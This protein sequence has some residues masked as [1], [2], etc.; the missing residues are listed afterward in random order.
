MMAEDVLRAQ[1]EHADADTLVEALPNGR[2]RVRVIA[3]RSDVRIARPVCETSYPLDL[4]RSVYEV[5][6]PA[7]VCDEIRRDEDPAASGFLIRKVALA[8]ATETDFHEKTL[9]DFG[10]GAG[11]ST[12]NLARLFPTST[13]V[14]VELESSLLDI[15]RRRAAH[16][17]YLNVSFHLSLDG[18]KLPHLESAFDFIFLCAVYEHLLPEERRQLFPQLWSY[19]KPGGLLF[20]LET[21]NRYWLIEGHTTRLPFLNFLPDALVSTL[22]RRFSRKIGHDE[23]WQQMLRRGIRGGSVREITRILRHDA[24]NLPTVLSPCG[25]GIHDRIDLCWTGS[26]R[27]SWKRRLVKRPVLRVLKLM[28]AITSISHVPVL[29]LAIRKGPDR[30]ARD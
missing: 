22:A 19:L 17:G 7:W 9:L 21:P 18:C 27:T 15:A 24:T 8:Y 26:G 16:Y 13:I 23:S 1:W 5:K 4:I 6:G 20:I 12:M 28:K 14:G 25:Q 10:C 11:S 29:E 3:K 2:T 30:H